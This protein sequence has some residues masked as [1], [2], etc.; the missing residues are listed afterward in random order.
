MNK[1]ML[2]PIVLLAMA[3]CNSKPQTSLNGEAEYVTENCDSQLLSSIDKVEIVTDSCDSQQISSADKL[4]MGKIIR[5]VVDLDLNDT[6]YIDLLPAIADEKDSIYIGFDFQQLEIIAQQLRNTGFFSETFIDYYKKKITE[7][8][9]AL[10]N[11]ELG[12]WD[13]RDMP[14]FGFA[15]DYGP[16]CNCQD[17][18]T[19][20][21]IS[22]KIENYEN[23]EAEWFYKLQDFEGNIELRVA[24]TCNFEKEDGRWKI[25]HLSGF[26]Y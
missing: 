9:R 24:V 1:I 25:S 4:E 26:D 18:Y 11:N 20:D 16:F 7:L 12:V 14:P 15:A 6:I 22:F 17:D 23:V 13:M 5:G 21:S 10:K 19:V 8:D 2:F 3:G